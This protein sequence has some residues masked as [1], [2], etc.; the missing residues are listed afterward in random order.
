MKLNV[1]A[2]C[3]GLW[4]TGYPLIKRNWMGAHA[5]SMFQ[6]NII[7][8]KGMAGVSVSPASPVESMNCIN[9]FPVFI[10]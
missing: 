5:S 8:K 2:I 1:P 6:N 9:V 7:N 10:F 4:I 3:S